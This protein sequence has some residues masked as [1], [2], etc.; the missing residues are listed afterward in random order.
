MKCR[1]HR[2]ATRKGSLAR[3]FIGVK[4][5]GLEKGVERMAKIANLEALGNDNGGKLSLK[6]SLS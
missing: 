4:E 2:R 5:P 1:E 3:F 6:E